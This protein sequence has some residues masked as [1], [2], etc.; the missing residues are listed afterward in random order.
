MPVYQLRSEVPGIVWKV[1]AQIG[2]SV[3]VGTPVMI[4]ESMKMEIPIIAERSGILQEVLVGEGEFV[5]EN[6]VVAVI[7]TSN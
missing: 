6:Q 5:D 7:E 3:A 2:A 4:I 1:A